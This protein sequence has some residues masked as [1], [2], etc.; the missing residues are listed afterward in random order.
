MNKKMSFQRDEFIGEI[1]KTAK[2][3]KKIFFLSAECGAPALDDF[4]FKLKSQFLH[5]GIC[6]QNM[7]DFAA[8]IPKVLLAEA[9][10]ISQQ[11]AKAR[12]PPMQ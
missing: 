8:G 1:Y 3:N 7:V 12:P 4:R 10:R 2:K 11:S 6:E 9:I 5:L